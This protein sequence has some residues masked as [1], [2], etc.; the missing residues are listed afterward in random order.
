MMTRFRVRKPTN[1]LVDEAA[2]D[3]A[4]YCAALVVQQLPAARSEMETPELRGYVRARACPVVRA[5]VQQAIA[6][7]LSAAREP[8]LFNAVLDR[9]VHL[10]ISDLR[11][12]PSII[13]ALPPLPQ[14][15]AA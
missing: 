12:R 9:T 5:R 1:R 11:A 2:R 13:A 15:E 8:H 10:V 6:D 4:A 14:R 3:I 7:G